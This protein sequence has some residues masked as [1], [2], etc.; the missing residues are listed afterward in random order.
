MMPMTWSATTV[1]PLL[2]SMLSRTPSFGA[3]TSSTTLSVSMS[4]SASS[5]TMASPGC[6]C[7]ATIT[8]SLTDSGS[9][10]TLISMLIV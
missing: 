8:P 9:A 4:T 1:S 5:R 3:G 7:H 10:G 6:L 2:M